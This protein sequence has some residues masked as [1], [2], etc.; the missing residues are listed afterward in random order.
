MVTKG[1][2]D[3]RT[4]ELLLETVSAKKTNNY[5]KK[6]I[7]R[8]NLQKKRKNKRRVCNLIIYGAAERADRE[9]RK[10]K[11]EELNRNLIDKNL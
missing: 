4:P 9:K 1:N 5:W 6:T 3:W 10:E 11:D 7:K 8:K 2:P